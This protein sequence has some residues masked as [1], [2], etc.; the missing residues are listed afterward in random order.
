MI[1][2]LACM[3]KKILSRI[4]N[5]GIKPIIDFGKYLTKKIILTIKILLIAFFLIEV[6]GFF[7]LKN[8]SYYWENRFQFISNN[9]FRIALLNT[10]PP[11][12]F[13]TYVPNREIETSAAYVLHKNIS[14]VEYWTSFKTNHLGL[15]ETNFNKDDSEVDY[16]ILGD[17]FLEGQGGGPWLSKKSIS[18]DYPKI[19]NAGL[20]GASMVSMHILESYISETIK[21]NN[22]VLVLISNDFK[23]F[24]DLNFLPVEECIENGFCN[25]INDWEPIEDFKSEEELLAL[26]KKKFKKRQYLIENLGYNPALHFFST[27]YRLYFYYKNIIE[28][29][30]NPGRE[31]GVD[32]F[33]GNSTALLKLHEKYP[34]MKIIFI[35]QRDEVGMLGKINHDT[36]NVINFMDKENINYN[37]CELTLSD[38]MLIDGHPNEDGYKKIYN[39]L[40][41]EIFINK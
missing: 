8:N 9:S 26:S 23:R 12:K 7:F 29:H 37:F 6:F 30:Y 18:K 4:K 20:Q 40:N 17:S 13:W 15:I 22:V 39:C 28:H 41:Q 31:G 11:T 5:I 21:I 19:I 27:T 10:D 35:P 33:K 25:T 38:Y 14:W 2:L 16:L 1:Q 32:H 24:V 3:F 36:R 34:N